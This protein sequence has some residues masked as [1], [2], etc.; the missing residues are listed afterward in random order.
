MISFDNFYRSLPFK[1]RKQPTQKQALFD[2]KTYK[3]LP[4]L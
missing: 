3:I 4:E 2:S 1:I